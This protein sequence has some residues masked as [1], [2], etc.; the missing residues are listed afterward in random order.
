[1][2]RKHAFVPLIFAAILVSGC[3]ASGDSQPH[4]ATRASGF[5]NFLVIG[6][7][8]SWDSRAQ[9]ERVVVSGL[10]EEGAKAQAYNRVVEGGQ[11]PSR[12]AVAAAI[13]EHGFDAVVVTQVVDS[14]ADVELRSGVTGA[15]VSRK[16]SGLM[17]LFRYDYEELGDP[18]NLTV[19]IQVS[20]QTEVYSA[21]TEELAWSAETKAAQADNIAILIDETAK[22]VVRQL[23]R[24]R[25]IAR[26]AQ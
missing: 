21:A 7:A 10:R 20:F 14:D 13:E 11:R 3:A 26:R 25:L 8:G 24:A 4:P 2:Y 15:K 5:S 9:F 17:K 19:D 23:K 6:V 22:S 1:M 16:D 12:E 18:L